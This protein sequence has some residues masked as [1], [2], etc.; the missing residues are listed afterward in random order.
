[1]SRE[2]KNNAD[3]KICRTACGCTNIHTRP[4]RVC[5]QKASVCEDERWLACVI[6]SL[7]WW[8]HAVPASNPRTHAAWNSRH[9]K[10]SSM[11]FQGDQSD[12]GRLQTTRPVTRKER[13]RRGA[14]PADGT[15]GFENNSS[16][17]RRLFGPLRPLWQSV[18]DSVLPKMAAP[19]AHSC[20]TLLWE[21]QLQSYF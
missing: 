11:E 13:K 10:H 20:W 19:S 17:S 6:M 4:W 15:E 8:G 9:P 3:R 7:G 16:V 5:S 21:L 2:K 18:R 12:R 1:M 14:R